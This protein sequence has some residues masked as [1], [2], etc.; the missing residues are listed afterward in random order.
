[1]PVNGIVKSN[2]D[3]NV[4]F[5]MIDDIQGYNELLSPEV[6]TIISFFNSYVDEKKNYIDT[7]LDSTMVTNVISLDAT[8]DVQ[9]RT[10]VLLKK[11]L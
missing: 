6:T 9:K 1:M 3:V 4:D 10:K 7:Y 2:I 11:N 5:K 8:F